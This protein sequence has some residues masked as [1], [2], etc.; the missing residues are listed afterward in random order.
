[1]QLELPTALF[2]TWHKWEA[3]TV[4]KKLDEPFAVT[5]EF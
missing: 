2:I 5:K 4:P 1:M 3:P